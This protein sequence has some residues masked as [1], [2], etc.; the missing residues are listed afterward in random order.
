MSKNKKAVDFGYPPAPLCAHDKAVVEDYKNFRKARTHLH[1][2]AKNWHLMSKKT[3][4]A[5]ITMIDLAVKAI[6]EGKL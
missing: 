6:E 1:F 5:V 2:H 4:Q 3:K